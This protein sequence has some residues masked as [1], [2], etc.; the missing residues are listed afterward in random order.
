MR[1]MNNKRVMYITNAKGDKL[2]AI[3]DIGD[4]EKLLESMEDLESI[5]EYDAAKASKD[6]IIPFERAVSEIEKRMALDQSRK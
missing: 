3:L 5:I 2:A 1:E 4:F 6:E